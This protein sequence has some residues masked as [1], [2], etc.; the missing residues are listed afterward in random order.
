[1]RSPILLLIA[2]SLACTEDVRDP[3]KG[4]KHSI[5]NVSPVVDIRSPAGLEEVSGS[6][7]VQAQIDDK[8]G[9][10]ALRMEVDGVDV[11]DLTAGP[12]APV[13][14]TTTVANGEHD[15]TILAA[16]AAGNVGSDTVRVLVHDPAGPDLGVVSV[17]SPLPGAVVCGT[18]PVVAFATEPVTQIVAFFDTSERDADLGSPY[19]WDFDTTERKNGVHT[20]TALATLVSGGMVSDRID[21]DIENVEGECD[22]WPGITLTEPDNGEYVNVS[23]DVTMEL[24]E[25]TDVDVVE[26]AVDGAVSWSTAIAPW[27]F[28]WDTTDV[29]EGAHVVSAYVT[30][31]GG[32]RAESRSNI[33]VDHTPPDAWIMTPGDGEAVGGDVNI[34]V[35]AE[36]EN[37]IARVKLSIGGEAQTELTAPPWIWTWDASGKQE[38]V[39]IVMRA[40]DVAGNSTGHDIT[41]IA[42]EPPGITITDPVDGDDVEGVISVT[43]ECTNTSGSTTVTF[44]ADGV[45]AGTDTHVPYR[46]TV[47]TC[48]LDPGDHVLGAGVVDS[49]G[50]SAETSITVN[51]D[52]SLTAEIVEPSGIVTPTQTFSALVS[53]DQGI[54]SVTFLI[55]GVAISG[56]AAPTSTPGECGGDCDD[57][58]VTYTLEHDVTDLASGDHFVDVSVVNDDGTSVAASGS[59]TVERDADG[60]GYDDPIWGG[61]DCDDTDGTIHPGGTE[62][63]DGVDEDCDGATDEDFDADSDGYADASACASGTDCDDADGDVNPGGTEICDGVD[64]DCDGYTDVS[65]GPTVAE[66]DFDSGSLNVSAS[67]ELRGNV[68]VPTRDL[69]L[70]TFEVD[71]DPGSSGTTYA[72]YEATSETGDYALVASIDDSST[73]T[74]AFYECDS[75]DITLLAGNYYLLAVGSTDAMETRQDRSPT[76]TEDGSLTPIG[77]IRYTTSATPTIVST[78]P[79]ATRLYSQRI[80]VEWT[81]SDD[82]DVDGDGQNEWCGDCDDTDAT[83]YDGAT[84]ACDGVDNDCNGTIPSDEVDGDS[85]GDRVCD[86]DC[87]D[88]DALRFPS[89][90][91]LCDGIDN[92]CDGDV[93]ADESDADGDGVAACQDCS[94]ATCVM[95]CDDTDASVVSPDW[96]A[97]LDGDGFGDD[98]TAT[99]ACPPP[100][101]Y[102]RIAGDC[103]DTDA[104]A[105]DGAVEICDAVDN[106]CD[107]VADDGFDADGDGVGSCDDCDDGDP[108][109]YPGATEICGDGVDNDCDGRAPG[110]RWSGAQN[111]Y[112]A[113]TVFYGEAAGDAAGA[114]ADGGDLNNDGD[115]DVLVGGSSSDSAYSDAGAVWLIHGP[116]SGAEDLGGTS[117][118]RMYGER[119]GDAAGYGVSIGADLNGDAY[120]DA[121]V[122]APSDDDAGFNAGSVYIVS[123]RTAASGSLGSAGW[124][125]VGE[126]AGD[127]LGYGV[128][129]PGDVNGDGDDDI[130]LGAPYFDGAASSAG[131]AYVFYGPITGDTDASAADVVVE[132]ERA[133]D[134]AGMR[135]ESAGDL[136]GDGLIDL[137]VGATGSDTSATTAGAVYLLMG[138]PATSSL[139][140]ADAKITGRA[141]SD[142]LGSSMAAAADVDGDGADDFIVGSGYS[143]LSASDAGSAWLFT[144]VPTG[145]VSVSTADAILTG[146]AT[147]DHAGLSVSGQGDIDA[148]GYADVVVGASAAGSTGAG[149]AYL[150]YGPLTGTM[151]LSL[152]D[153]SFEGETAGDNA[154]IYVTAP[155]DGDGD[156][157]PDLLIGASGSDL[158]GAASGAS[159]LVTGGQ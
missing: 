135:V 114:A 12:W 101:G 107:G 95:D 106:D 147:S 41:V 90:P 13:W 100:A 37:G 124:K 74:D 146:E 71:M 91:E 68:Y 96:Y 47:D 108:D 82:T 9:I 123:G 64:N 34:E 65:G 110:C 28:T 17:I 26:F 14:D 29:T 60:D 58:C 112:D 156:G 83:S 152:A 117:A 36:D 18:V 49:L 141:A 23:H 85:D 21:V 56:L 24:T 99:T 84:E 143:D 131:G 118:V 75:L 80:H 11:V 150:L 139:S 89:S 92:D 30:D 137:L 98:T 78:N 138:P 127:G 129:A 122:S 151:S 159:Y 115:V 39:D 133:S 136:D 3:V 62:S 2:L 50:L 4:G 72:V 105:N 31:L 20:I 70:T 19:D 140:S 155:G 130:F 93:T 109:A 88:A 125:I 44:T 154:G 52:Q 158:G 15:I 38:A 104:S 42:G 66:G 113:D 69:T 145:T 142:A 79:D 76:L 10:V 121:L 59:F 40:Y 97:D 48:L 1:M 61:D 67:D 149:I 148:D 73:G 55:D 144:H 128:S 16:D 27:A 77:A 86:A 6:V 8:E 25:P 5:D 32:Q 45:D 111:L 46:A 153:A 119:S 53:D 63:C 132:G 102:I 134:M 33:I 43:A 51:V 22:R 126:V 35:N 57:L 116:F 157:V 81:E 54:D 7:T 94:G 103:D 120:N 87:D